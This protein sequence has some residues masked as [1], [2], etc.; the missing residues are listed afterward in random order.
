VIIIHSSENTYCT[1]PVTALQPGIQFQGIT[2]NNRYTVVEPYQPPPELRSSPA[3]VE[4]KAANIL[5]MVFNDQLGGITGVR[6][7]YTIG[8]YGV[9]VLG[10][11]VFFQTQKDK[12]R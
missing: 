11:E 12:E 3:F 8:F 5:R 9:N 2:T 7:L 1:K 6:D 10:M 4:Q